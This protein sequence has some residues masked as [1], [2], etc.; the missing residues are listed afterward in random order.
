MK[1]ANRVAINVQPM[2]NET[3]FIIVSILFEVINKSFMVYKIYV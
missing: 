2:I 3:M 1:A